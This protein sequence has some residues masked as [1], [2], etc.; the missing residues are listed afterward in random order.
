M[1]TMQKPER[2]KGLYKLLQNPLVYNTYQ[3]LVG[4]K[5]CRRKVVE[6]YLPKIEGLRIL[7][8]GCG[9]GYILDYLSDS[10]EYLGFD[11]SED[12]I[13]IAQK[14]YGHRGQLS[15]EEAKDLFQIGFQALKKGGKMITE[16]GTF[17]P[18]QNRFAKFIIEKDRGTQVRTPENYRHLAEHF[19]KK[20]QTTIRHDLFF[21][22]YTSCVME[23]I[24][25]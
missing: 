5:N 1:I 11:L 4:G 17:I 7:D 14:K 20:I 6:D 10:I 23:C 15:D 8:I 3:T 12:Y 24:K 13:Q 25:I 9:T 19:F 21:I 2:N 16:D 18:K 22:P